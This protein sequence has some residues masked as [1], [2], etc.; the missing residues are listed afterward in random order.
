MKV[1]IELPTWLGD[2]IMAT[3][4]IENIV[5]FY[6]ESEITFIGSFVSIE[7]MKN[8]PKVVKI[9]ILDK[10]YRSL[11]KT[12]RELGGFDVFFSFRSS[13][14][15]KFL[16]FSISAKNKYQFDKNKYINCHQVKKY[17][18]FVNDCLNINSN[19]ERLTL[20]K[21]SRFSK[22]AR[23][24]ILGINPG[25]SYGSAK[26]WYPEKFVKVA[27]ELSSQYDIVIFGGSIE[28]DIATDI[29]KG[30][31]DNGVENYQNFAGKT[32]ISELINKISDLDLFI[33][34]DSGPMHVA[35]AFQVPTV[36]IFGP[37]KDNETSQWMNEKS[38]IVKQG[39]ECQPCM[40]RTCPLKHHNCMKSIEADDILDA[41]K[42]LN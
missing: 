23:K 8:H 26:R 10:K 7:A 40:K 12:A 27:S 29:E 17:N 38:E 5:N 11:Y 42:R 14:R 39:L 32:T 35:A 33:T 3:P 41:I 16:K 24:S 2:A 1:L 15:S 19:P 18:D 21:E 13:V 34:G 31:I 28:I 20:Y 4:A 25:A 37:T 36:A 6:N 30:L 22:M 9:V